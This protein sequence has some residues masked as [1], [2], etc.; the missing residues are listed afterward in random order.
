MEELRGQIVFRNQGSAGHGMNLICGIGIVEAPDGNLA[1]HVIRGFSIS[2]DTTG[3]VLRFTDFAFDIQELAR[4]ADLSYSMTMNIWPRTSPMFGLESGG[5]FF[6]KTRMP[7]PEDRAVYMLAMVACAKPGTLPGETMFSISG[8][9]STPIHMAGDSR[10]HPYSA[11][12]R[13]DNPIH[14]PQAAAEG[15]KLESVMEKPLWGFGPEPLAFH[16]TMDIPSIDEMQELKALYDK[17]SL[18][19][20]EEAR[21]QYLKYT[22]GGNAVQN[23]AEDP[24]YAAFVKEM[25]KETG[26]FDCSGFSTASQILARKELSLSI[27]AR[28]MSV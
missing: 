9:S 28:Q 6:R 10:L 17:E 1:E 22:P 3:L 27:V 24:Q 26:P 18:T 25:R 11:T 2:R 8:S 14:C 19:P 7:A 12:L 15:N 16:S 13:L 4:G 23:P 21:V 5:V 20:E